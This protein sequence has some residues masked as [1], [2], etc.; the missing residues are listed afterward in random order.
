MIADYCCMFP[1][2]FTR[3]KVTKEHL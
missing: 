1:A 2:K 3:G